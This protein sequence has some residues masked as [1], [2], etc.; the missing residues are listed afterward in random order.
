MQYFI[1]LHV[2]LLTCC[3][4][5]YCSYQLTMYYIYEFVHQHFTH[6]DKSYGLVQMLTIAKYGQ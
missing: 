5:N 2:T 1:K 3:K 6:S 4:F